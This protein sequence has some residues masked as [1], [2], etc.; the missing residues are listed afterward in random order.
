MDA[1]QHFAMSIVQPDY[2]EVHLVRPSME[3]LIER[4]NG[5]L[6]MIILQIKKVLNKLH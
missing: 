2:L 6:C 1:D 5:Q 4:T 3:I